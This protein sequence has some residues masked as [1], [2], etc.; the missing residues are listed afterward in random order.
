MSLI[1]DESIN[2]QTDE[3]YMVCLVK[4]FGTGLPWNQVQ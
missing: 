1:H 4:L 2:A 3:K